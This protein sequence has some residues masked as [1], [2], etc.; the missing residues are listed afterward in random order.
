MWLVAGFLALGFLIGNLVGMSATSAVTALLGL[1]FAFAGGSILAFLEK[2][3]SVNLRVASQALLALSLACTIGLYTGIYVSEHQLLS[4]P[5]RFSARADTAG[6][7]AFRESVESRKYLRAA[8]GDGVEAVD[9]LRR[10]GDL[11]DKAAYEML[12]GNM[13][14]LAR[15]STR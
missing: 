1:L 9:G 3:S 6:R 7:S 12:R 10:R 13:L 11:N 14:A 4:P 5:E 15:D 2:F 8:I